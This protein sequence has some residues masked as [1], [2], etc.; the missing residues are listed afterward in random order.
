MGQQRGGTPVT[1][2]RTAARRARLAGTAI[3][4]AAI[5]VA[6]RGARLA[7]TAIGVAAIG[8]LAGCG[9]SAGSASGSSTPAAHAT[10]STA[11]AAAAATASGA[12]AATTSAAAF[13]PIVEPFDPGHPA[14]SKPAP[15]SCGGQSSTLA[16]EQC[17]EAR[18]ENADAAIDAV[19]LARY[20]SGSQAQ[21]AA[22]AAGDSAW[23]SARQP[24][25][26]KAFHSGGTIDGI[27]TAGCLLSESTARLDALKGIAPPEAVL[28]STD[29]TDPSALSWYTTPE[30]SRIAMTDTQG[31]STGGVIIAWVV[32]GGADGFLVN[33][34]QF[35]YVDGSFTDQGKVQAPNPAGHRVSPGAEYQ[36]DIDYSHVSADPHAGQDTGGW[37][38]APGT[39]VAVWR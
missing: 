2:G 12:G 28:K 21:R 8:A 34:A 29:N 14:T 39:P 35:S 37:V 25:C 24:V 26:A 22:I 11:R 33:P 3:G 31:D 19:Q 36:F 15:A 1:G 30:G 5:G 10:A 20:Q 23:L 27:G 4:V 6:T 38:Y 32:I 9:G 16:I 17:Y 18:T 13:T 7:G